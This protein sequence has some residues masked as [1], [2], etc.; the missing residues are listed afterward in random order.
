MNLVVKCVELIKQIAE[1]ITRA[2]GRSFFVGGYVRDKILG[3]ENHDIDI[4]VFFLSLS[5]L[6]TILADFGTVEQMGKAFGILKL[7]EY[8]QFDFALPRTEKLIGKGH[9]AFDIKVNKDLSFKNAAIRRDFTCNAIMEDVIT[10]EIHDYFGGV[11]DIKMQTLRHVSDNSFAE[12]ALRGLRAAQFAARFNFTIASETITLIQELSYEHLSIER[13][14]TELQKGLLCGNSSYFLVKLNQ[15]GITKKILPDFAL[16]SDS[17][18][19]SLKHIFTLLD[20]QSFAKLS[21]TDKQVCYYTMLS[22]YLLSPKNVLHT[23]TANKKHQKLA[24]ELK[25]NLLAVPTLEDDIAMRKLKQQLVAPECFW[26]LLACIASVL[27]Q[28]LPNKL[29]FIHFKEIFSLAIAN[30]PTNIPL[31]QG[32]DL[33]LLGYQPSKDFADLLIFA[34]EQE[35]LGLSKVEILDSIVQNYQK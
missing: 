24:L 1:K 27:P 33:I 15:L 34:Q 9:T 4:E 10:Q 6:E 19:N 5:E 16:L 7:L 30:N 13:I 2:G 22:F 21:Q 32:K 35:M 26:L 8:P 18:F 20:Q 11:T 14:Q 23:F 3:I 25:E 29:D 12:D 28:F 17:D 31:V